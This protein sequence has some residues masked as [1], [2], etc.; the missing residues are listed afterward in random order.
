M[1]H[2]NPVYILLL[3]NLAG[4]TG[5]APKQRKKVSPK[6]M[7]GEVEIPQPP[8]I[9]ESQ[10]ARCRETGD[11][12]PL[13]FEWYKYVGTL[14][15]FYSCIRSDSAA[16]RSLPTLHYA[17]LVGLLNRCSRLIL[18][19]VALSH[20]GLF[21]ETTAILDRCIFE[22]AVKV[23]WLCTKGDDESFSRFIADGL[24]TELEF[25]KKIEKNISDRGGTIL[26]IEK[27]MLT[28]ISNY[29]SCSGLTEPQIE[30]A[31]KLPDMAA[32]IDVIGRDRLLYVVGQKIGSHHVHGTWPSLWLH[33]L[34]EQDGMLGPRDHD[35]PTHVNQYVFVPLLVL[36]AVDA[37]VRFICTDQRDARPMSELLD[38]VRDEIL[39]FYVE[40][41]GDDFEH[42]KEI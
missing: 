34:D 23:I 18:A 13:L 3:I 14:S 11:Y 22:S 26:A 31:K 2:G 32:M 27:R 4:R 10:L 24:K 41:V 40:V 5:G 15:N 19:N 16:V 21:G 39:R 20:K 37:F 38:S 12:R 17:T 29:V 6:P 33:Y 30:S 36:Q 35:C 9:T 42:I 1:T 28:S 8:T 25:K 7:T